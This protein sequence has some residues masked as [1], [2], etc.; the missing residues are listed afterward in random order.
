MYACIEET[1]TRRVATGL[2]LKVAPHWDPYRDGARFTAL[3]RRM[4]LEE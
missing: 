1:L 2:Y 4:G 3:L